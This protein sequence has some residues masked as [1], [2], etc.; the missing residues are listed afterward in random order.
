[1]TL[2]D[3]KDD[4]VT[5]FGASCGFC[6]R[7]C[8][9]YQIAKKKTLTSRG[10]NRTILGIIEGKVEPS[11]ALARAYYQ[12][13]MCG[14]CERWC[15]LPDTEIER[16]LRKYLV[17]NGFENEKHKENVENVMEFGNPYGQEDLSKWKEGIKFAS[18][19][20]SSTLFFAGCTMPLKQLETLRRTVKLLGPEKMVVTENPFCCGS[21]VLRTGYE[22]EYTEL[23][24]RI[25]DYLKDLD[26]REVI[27]PCPGCFTTLKEM[28]TEKMPD[29]KV[30]HTTQRLKEM[31]DSGEIVVERKIGKT[32]YHDP[33]HLGRLEG[34][35]MEPRA[36]LE[37]ISDFV[38]MPDSG[39]DSN[40]CG[41]GGGVRAAFPELS[42]EIGKRR[43]REAQATGADIL[44]SSCPFCEGQFENIGGMKVMDIVDALWEAVK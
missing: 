23:A 12:C 6:E 24:N 16:E 4:I 29:I 37:R 44:V 25:L 15:A 19:G 34:I 42:E 5:C 8:P 32:T 11:E 2:E 33:C 28:L 7:K 18:P 26:I 35:I 14:C 13:M 9:V 27:T 30:I 41:A 22:K 38:E 40:C 20:E 3:Y 10:R 17:E 21:Y 31:L 39:Y 43:I 1:M 36:I